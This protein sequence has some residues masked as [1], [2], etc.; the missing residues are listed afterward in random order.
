MACL[1][2]KEQN[3]TSLM[4]LEKVGEQRV[5]SQCL[6]HFWL[7]LSC[8]PAAKPEP[9]HSCLARHCFLPCCPPPPTIK[10][11]MRTV[12]P[13]TGP[14]RSS[15]PGDVFMGTYTLFLGKSHRKRP[16][17]SQRELPWLVRWRFLTLALRAARPRRLTL[18]THQKF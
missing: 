8:P 12:S 16:H 14:R 2:R 9:S 4:I 15:G 7:L 1:H 17:G 10:D 6:L 18:S 11:I 5:P 13:G 3:A